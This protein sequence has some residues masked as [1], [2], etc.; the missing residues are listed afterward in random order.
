MPNEV[1]KK[2]ETLMDEKAFKELMESYSAPYYK[3]SQMRER[4]FIKTHLPLKLL[5]KSVMEVGAKVV[6]VARN[7]KDMAAS[8]FKFSKT[9][10]TKYA[11]DF[12]KFARYFMDDLSRWF[13]NI[14]S[15]FQET[16]F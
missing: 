9:N 15:I 2:T 6:Y 10:P 14:G 7:P 12:E 13:H 1:I 3:L 5:P 4:R 11:G 8:W 16:F